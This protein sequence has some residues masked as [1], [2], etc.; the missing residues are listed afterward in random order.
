MED[1][2]PIIKFFEELTNRASE[3]TYPKNDVRIDFFN[4][5]AGLAQLYYLEQIALESSVLFKNKKLRC[6]ELNFYHKIN[7][8]IKLAENE[9]L[10]KSFRSAT[11]RGLII[12]SWSSFEVC[13]SAICDK[14]YSSEDKLNIQNKKYEDVIKC[15]KKYNLD[16]EIKKKLEKILV[17]KEFWLTSTNSK[18]NKLLSLLKEKYRRE[19]KKDRDFLEFFGKLRNTM[20][21]NF[22]YF[23]EP[24][25]YIFEGVE[26]IF[27]KK[28]L[29]VNERDAHPLLFLNMI[30]RLTEIYTEII[31]HFEDT[32]FIPYPDQYAEE[33]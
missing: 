11:N 18:F 32:G 26:F 30:V 10:Y 8:F 22:V 29:V 1:Y 25:I 28:Q 31:S 6:T 17:E 19:I 23:G 20:H 14:I 9:V 3:S 12:D 7:D 16:E 15:L 27:D 13:L 21:S 24:F 33:Y 2:K 5:I 4:L